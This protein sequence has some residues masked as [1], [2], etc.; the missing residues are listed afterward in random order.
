[1]GG[2]KGI[3][4][5]EMKFTE[6]KPQWMRDLNVEDQRI[7]GE[8]P[9]VGS[10]VEIAPRINARLLPLGG[11]HTLSARTLSDA[12]DHMQQVVQYAGYDVYHGVNPDFADLRSLSSDVVNL[13]RLTIEP[14]EEG[15]FV[16]PARL[17]TGPL[18]REAGDDQPTRAVSAED[19]MQRF[20][21][22]FALVGQQS[23]AAEVSIGAIQAVESLGRVLRRE[24][25]AIEFSSFDSLGAPRKPHPIRVDQTFIGRVAKVKA[26]RQPTLAKSDTLNGKITA[27]DIS[28]G[29]LQL[30]ID[31]HRRRVRGTFAML[32]LPS[33]Q[34]SLGRRVKLTGQVEWRGRTPL[35]IQVT[36]TEVLSDDDM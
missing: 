23:T 18:T 27:L 24:V 22:I 17:E 30:S 33:L 6:F 1:M 36:S 19:V 31:G 11:L 14:F 4:V 28:E 20:E 10:P 29:K 15:S 7:L 13:T 5:S 8:T 21:E 9:S 3:D 34:E 35:S 12:I 26:S 32:M 16:I 2:W 25:E